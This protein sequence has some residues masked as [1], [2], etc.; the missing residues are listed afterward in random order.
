MLLYLASFARH[1]TVEIN[2]CC[3]VSVTFTDESYWQL[4]IVL[5]FPLLRELWAVWATITNPALDNSCTNLFVDI[6][7]IFISL[8]VK[9]WNM[10]NCIRNCQTLEC[11]FYTPTEMYTCSSCST[12]PLHSALLLHWPPFH[13][14]PNNRRDSSD[15][16][17]WL[18]GPT[19]ENVSEASSLTAKIQLISLM[20]RPIQH[21]CYSTPHLWCSD[22]MQDSVV[23]CPQSLL[24]T[25]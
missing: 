9:K 21:L 1:N 19:V 25:G 23:T 2:P 15:V 24:T 14:L 4:T 16:G 22:K 8:L 11:S 13:F 6:R 20:F 10:F 18:S 12:W 7:F 5:S 3:C 17:I